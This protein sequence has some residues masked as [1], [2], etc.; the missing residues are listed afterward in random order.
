MK[1]VKQTILGETGNCFAACVASILE[2]ELNDV[3]KIKFWKHGNNWQIP[4]NK[5]LKSKGLCYVPIKGGFDFK[6]DVYYISCML[7][8][9][10]PVNYHA[11]VS[12]KG[13]IVHDP[14]PTKLKLYEEVEIGLFIKNFL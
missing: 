3:P 14:F 5:W 12:R 13:K 2:C 8:N 1:P 10:N 11:V 4:F 6:K 7:E 9:K